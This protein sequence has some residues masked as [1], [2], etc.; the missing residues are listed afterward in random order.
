MSTINTNSLIVLCI[1]FLP[2]RALA[3]SCSVDRRTDAYRAAF[4]GRN[5][6]MI[7]IVMPISCLQLANAAR[8]FRNEG[9]LLAI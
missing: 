6:A 3:Y 2:A 7:G 5:A 1:W 4:S 9:S 8:A